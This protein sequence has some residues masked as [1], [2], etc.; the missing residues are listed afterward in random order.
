[1]DI[2]RLVE[3][4]KAVNTAM[5]QNSD[6]YRIR[7]SDA[8]QNLLDSG[9]G[10]NEIICACAALVTYYDYDGRITTNNKRWANEVCCENDLLESK[11]KKIGFSLSYIST[12]R[13]SLL[14][15]HI[16]FLYE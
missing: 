15:D 7:C 16:R 13:L 8:I 11:I 9:Y 3:T 10:R 4:A 2:Q 5:N 6:M 14:V 1:M 12:G